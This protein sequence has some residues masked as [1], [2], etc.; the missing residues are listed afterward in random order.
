MKP[1]QLALCVIL[2]VPSLITGAR[3]QSPLEA[4]S[5][6]PALG[7]RQLVESNTAFALDL[8]QALA[9]DGNLVFSPFGLS[10]SLAICLDG[11][12]GTG[13][14]GRDGEN[15]AECKL[16]GFHGVTPLEM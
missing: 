4:S 13:D 12:R 2:A 6:S 8:H 5:E 14:Q 15:D 1:F 11:A 10:E 16:E 7:L 9:S 3:A